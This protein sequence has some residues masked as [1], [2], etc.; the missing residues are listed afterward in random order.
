MSSQYFGCSG[1][2]EELGEAE[3]KVR[4]TDDPIKSE[5]KIE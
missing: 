3:L 5:E 4:L 1:W 2:I